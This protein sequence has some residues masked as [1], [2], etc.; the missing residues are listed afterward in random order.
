[1]AVMKNCSVLLI[2]LC[3][4]GSCGRSHDVIGKWR[5]NDAN[6][7]V[8]EFTPNGVVRIGVDEGRYTFGDQNRMKIQTRFAT[9][10]YQM[11]FSG[12]KLI[13]RPPKGGS[14]ELTRVK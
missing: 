12:E 2:V 9:S 7:V 4:L 11:E 1:M 10:V 14:M 13:L 6:S 8:W 5:T 3:L